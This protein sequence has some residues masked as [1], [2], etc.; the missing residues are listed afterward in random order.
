MA[1]NESKRP[2]KG[3]KS[4]VDAV[5]H[6]VGTVSD[7]DLAKQIGVTPENV[8]TWR[9]R[10]GIEATWQTDFPQVEVA[11]KPPKK[12]KKRK[13]PARRKSKLDPFAA[14]LGTVPDRVI[15]E[16]AGVSAENVRMY[17]KR[18][19]ITSTWRA[20]E[21]APKA[22][23]APAATPE[24]EAETIRQPP[25]RRRQAPAPNPT[26]RSVAAPA[27]RSVA[28][29]APR[30]TPTRGWAFRVTADVDGA[31]R[32]YVTFGA[33]VVE[34]AQVARDRLVR[35]TPGAHI[36]KIEVVGVAL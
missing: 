13:K 7:R 14:E 12:R 26:P 29:P 35:G 17:R 24:P 31:E 11:A 8:R 30:S 23:A 6:L 10:R 34:A 18:H 19:G 33:D 21:E 16:K 32:E 25:E 9:R 5:A 1:G 28:A 2:F 3:R 36:K 4:K 15:A 20:A 27:P 22:S